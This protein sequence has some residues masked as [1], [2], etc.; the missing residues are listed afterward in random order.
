M[1]FDPQKC[2][3]QMYW[4][5][6]ANYPAEHHYSHYNPSNKDMESTNPVNFSCLQKLSWAFGDETPIDDRDKNES[7]KETADTDL[8]ICTLKG[9]NIDSSQTIKCILS[10]WTAE[11]CFSWFPEHITNIYFVWLTTSLYSNCRV[12][13][14]HTSKNQTQ[15]P[16]HTSG[17]R[18]L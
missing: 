12:F 17:M 5:M 16:E 8:H 4:W 11:A 10:R 18:P 7:T 14:V 9:I 6:K 15:W 13:Q 1:Y 3:L 2:C